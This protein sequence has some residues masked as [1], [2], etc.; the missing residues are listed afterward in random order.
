MVASIRPPYL[1]TAAASGLLFGA[2]LYV[3]QMVDP[4]KVLRF[5]DFGAIP[6]GRWDPSLAFVIVAAIAVMF[7]AVRYGNTRKAPLF[8][9]QF[10]APEFTRIDSPLVVGAALFGIG[11]GMSGICPGPAISLIA[12]W[13]DNLPIFLVALF[14]GSYAGALIVPSGRDKRL[15]VAR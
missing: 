14:A 15:A 1:V 9:T 10:H 7:V 5:L 2:G 11:W 12:F 6:T 3:S 8:D 13:P 4:L